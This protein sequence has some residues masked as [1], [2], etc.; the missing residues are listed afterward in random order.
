[1]RK[2]LV[3]SSRVRLIHLDEKIGLRL[4]A[5]T[6]AESW[7]QSHV[8]SPV[9]A[10][11]WSD[12]LRQLIMYKIGGT[13]LDAAAIT[14]NP[15]TQL[16]RFY[17]TSNCAYIRMLSRMKP[18]FKDRGHIP[19]VLLQDDSYNQ[20]RRFY[21]QNKLL[22]G[23]AAG[24]PVFLETISVLVKAFQ[25]ARTGF[26]VGG[27]QEFSK[28][29]AATFVANPNRSRMLFPVAARLYVLSGDKPNRR[30]RLSL[31]SFLRQAFKPD[32]VSGALQQA[33]LWYTDFN[34]GDM[35]IG[36][37]AWHVQQWYTHTLQDTSG[38]LQ[39]LLD[40]ALYN[41]KV[42]AKN[43]MSFQPALWPP[44]KIMGGAECH[45]ASMRQ[46][47]NIQDLIRS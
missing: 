5:G 32:T 21:V 45:A 17:G 2:K 24:D 1:M 44:I 20:S 3:N 6:P 46:L 12:L 28:A 11:R 27:P 36:S 8:Q 29:V 34:E 9:E 38:N 47:C 35:E 10:T 13:Y 42:P 26:F 31:R 16:H 40:T 4:A 23:F 22:F 37:V 18:H 33:L 14:I 25:N 19:N 15:V 7:M 30:N 39:P 41:K 43:S